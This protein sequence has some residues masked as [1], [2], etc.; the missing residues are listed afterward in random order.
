LHSKARVITAGH[1]LS[2]DDLRL[3]A[4]HR[5]QSCNGAKAKKS[6]SGLSGEAARAW[7]ILSKTS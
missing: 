5:R 2:V 7:R 4:Y 3:I 6:L 1:G